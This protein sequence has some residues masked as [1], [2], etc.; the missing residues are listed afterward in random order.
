MKISIPNTDEVKEALDNFRYGL[1]D[2]YHRLAHRNVNDTKVF[3]E[4]IEQR[5][6]L[7]MMD[8]K[9]LASLFATRA[10]TSAYQLASYE[11]HCVLGTGVSIS[12]IQ[13]N[14][15]DN[16]MFYTTV[17]IFLD[18]LDRIELSEVERSNIQALQVI[19]EVKQRALYIERVDRTY[20]YKLSTGKNN[21]RIVFEAM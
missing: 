5:E 10:L 20:E 15:T 3:C 18:H 19:K 11:P 13:V 2:E 21:Y 14:G 1:S 4:F 16:E 6:M 8:Y 17:E 9:T 7:K 12:L